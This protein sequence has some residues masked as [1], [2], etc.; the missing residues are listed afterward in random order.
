MKRIKQVWLA[1]LITSLFALHACSSETE[2]PAPPAATGEPA[3]TT[4]TD[5][6]NEPAQPEQAAAE[7][8]K[9]EQ[10]AALKALVPDSVPKIPESTEEFYTL[11]PGRFSGML[12]ADNKE[13]IEQVLRQFPLIDQP[14]Q[15]AIDLYYR[16]LLALFAEDYPDPQELIDQIKLAS[17]GSPEMD[18][19]RFRFKEQ[20]NVEI[21]LDASGSMAAEVN[22][23]TK[24]EAAKEAIRA[25]AESLPEKANVALRVYG[26]KGSGKDSDKALS[27][28]SSELV[29]QLQ[30]YQ[31]Q[32][33]S[34]ALEK[35]KPAGW[36][37]IALALQQAQND[38]GR[39]KGENSTNI[40]YLVSDGIETC[41]GNPVEVAKQL[42][43]SDI[44]PIVNVV[45]FGVDGEG[46]KQLKEVAHAAGG[47]Y[48]HIQD[49]SELEKEF[50]RAKEAANR[51]KAWKSDASY[52]AN[53]THISQSLDILE[54]ALD[55]KAIARDESYNINSAIIA[56][57]YFH[58]LP[59]SVTDELKKRKDRQLHTALQRAEELEQFLDSLNDKSYKEAREAIDKQFQANV[60]RTNKP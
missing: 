28:A 14:D 1:F 7:P 52:Q 11:A 23:K 13:E 53:S 33:L 41:G 17:F 47:R 46:Q 19:P 54:F 44:T 60:G 43:S 34:D 8:D 31:A 38:L 48:V 40:I 9:E 58:I 5:K 51:W 29:Y 20:Y 3:G 59:D 15:E 49:Q 18:D 55:W 42:A 10:L 25:F 39:F 32:G 4:D 27:C 21:L 57:D 26:H 30:H 35:F 2:A 22:G 36:T 16:A 56:L 50:N 37:P 12:Y 45:G 24:M 6:G